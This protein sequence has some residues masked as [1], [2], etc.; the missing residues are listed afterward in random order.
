MYRT[1]V[2]AKLVAHISSES[3][4]YN[5]ESRDFSI[6]F[7]GSDFTLNIDSEAATATTTTVPNVHTTPLLRPEGCTQIYDA[8]GRDDQECITFLLEVGDDINELNSDGNSPLNRAIDLENEGMVRFL[9][10]RSADLNHHDSE[11]R[12]AA[13]AIVTDSKDQWSGDNHHG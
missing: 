8:V 6:K 3:C 2:F 11:N 4:E 9:V 7:E 10:E 5:H 1:L 13:Y 12:T